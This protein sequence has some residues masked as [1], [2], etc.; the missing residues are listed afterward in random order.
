VQSPDPVL[1]TVLGK[2]AEEEAPVAAEAG[3]AEAAER[4]GIG[5]MK[6]EEEEEASE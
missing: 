2:V 5:R 4:D 6:K 3:A 1:F